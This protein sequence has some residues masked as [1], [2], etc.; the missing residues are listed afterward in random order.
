MR[1]Y[2]NHIFFIRLGLA[3]VFLY[4]GISGLLNPSAWVGFLP[5][6]L[7]FVASLSVLLLIFSIFEIILALLL[8]FWHSPY[9]AL[10]SAL[11]LIS[12]VVFNFGAI[13]T[14]FR[15]IGMFFMAIALF[16]HERHVLKAKE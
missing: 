5:V 14:L 11:L 7:E 12:I 16:M 1:P 4:A 13:D 3:F 9:P 2:F 6:W 8:L 15:D 10:I